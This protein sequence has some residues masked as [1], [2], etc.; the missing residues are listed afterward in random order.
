MANECRAIESLPAAKLH[1]H[2]SVTL[3]FFVF[4]DHKGVRQSSCRLTFDPAASAIELPARPFFHF[5][6]HRT[7][8]CLGF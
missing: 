6:D 8:F 5:E 1:R 4:I 7:V 2:S 3:L